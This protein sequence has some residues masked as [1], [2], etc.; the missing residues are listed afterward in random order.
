M[1]VNRVENDESEMLADEKRISQDNVRIAIVIEDGI[2]SAAYSS[3]KNVALEIVEL[4]KNYADA[5]QRDAAYELYSKDVLLKPC[6]Y[7]LIVP[8]YCESMELEV[9]D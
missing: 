5:E 1:V 4:D 6:D 8:G 3:M 9:D 7:S 2:I